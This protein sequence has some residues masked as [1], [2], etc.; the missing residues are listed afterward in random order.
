[1]VFWMLLCP[2]S[3]EQRRCLHQRLEGESRSGDASLVFI[4][5][6]LLIFENLP[7]AYMMGLLKNPRIDRCR[8]EISTW[9]LP[10]LPPP[11]N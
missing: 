5:Q 6:F 2:N 11:P 7:E 8:R 10:E 3:L 9:P 1:M 4:W